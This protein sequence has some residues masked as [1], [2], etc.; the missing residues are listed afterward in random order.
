MNRS[1]ESALKMERL[2]QFMAAH[3]LAGLALSRTENFAWV[4]CGAD[5]SV[6]TSSETGMGT[7]L[8]R[9][10]GVTLLANNIEAERLLS[11]ELEGT[12]ITGAETYPWHEPERRGEI[13]G[14]MGAGG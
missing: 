13:I 6:V 3:E 14:R 7:L 10:G 12:G 2:E 8:V 4:G 1:E 5:N 11:E 9:P